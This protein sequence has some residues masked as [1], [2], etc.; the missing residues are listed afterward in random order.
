[1]LSFNP[2]TERKSS[3]MYGRNG[4]GRRGVPQGSSGDSGS[5]L[6]PSRVLQ[7]ITAQYHTHNTNKWL[8]RLQQRILRWKAIPLRQAQMSQMKMAEPTPGVN[9]C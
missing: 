2:M 9:I 1:M 5:S 3:Q 6:V 8:K 7:Y 4:D